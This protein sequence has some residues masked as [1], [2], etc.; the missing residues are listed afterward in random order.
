MHRLPRGEFAKANCVA[1]A[2]WPSHQMTAH[3]AGAAASRILKR[4][5]KDG[6]VRWGSDARDW[7]YI[8]TAKG[9][10]QVRGAD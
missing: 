5:E 8:I 4:M 1:L 3:G 9:R 7:G 10:E 6:L 2:I